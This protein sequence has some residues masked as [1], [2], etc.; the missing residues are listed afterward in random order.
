MNLIRSFALVI[1]D[2]FDRELDR[3]PLDYAEAPKNLGFEVQFTTLE[4]RLTTVFTS[5]KE[6]KM[7]TTL[8][9]NFLPPQAYEKANQFKQFVQKY[10]H[11]RMVFEYTDTTG[12]IKNWEGKIQKFDQEELTEWGGLVCPI[13]FLPATPKY[14]RKDNTIYITYSEQGKSYPFE[15]PYQYS[16]TLIKNNLLDNVYFDEVPL[17]IIIYGRI[18]NPHI[19]LVVEGE[20]TQYTSV[21]FDNLLIE[22]DEHLVI[23]GI[24][25]KILLWRRGEYVSAYD[26]VSK[27]ADLDTFLFARGNT[28]S[29]V[30][31]NLNPDD[32]GYLVASY[33]Q[34]TL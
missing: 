17:R 19:G 30:A 31:I 23:D 3:Y 16:E 9:L 29:I 7:A 18:K 2:D 27:Q 5:A 21:R 25:S 22:E 32:T 15:Y 12:V 1:I 24:R 13:S 6:K 11:S 14:I 26:Y 20:T 10:M 33:R 8:S 34:Y 4:S 28:K